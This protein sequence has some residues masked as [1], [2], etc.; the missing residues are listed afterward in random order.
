MID[1]RMMITAALATLASPSRNALAPGRD[2]PDYRLCLLVSCADRGRYQACRLRRPS[3][4]G[5]QHGLLVRFHAAI[6][7]VAGIVDRSFGGEA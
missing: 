3:A 2:E 4:A 5:G 7:R 1:R 6:C